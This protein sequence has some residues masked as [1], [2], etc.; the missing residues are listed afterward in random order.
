[1]G[2]AILAFVVIFLLAGSGLLLLFYRETLGQRLADVLSPRANS[3]DPASGKR[4]SLAE[5]IQFKK[6]AESL[7]AFAPSLRQA[8]EARGSAATGRQRLV[9]GGYRS[10]IA[11]NIFSVCKLIV[12]IVLCAASLV[13]G[14]Y[15]PILLL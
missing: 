8:D 14:L 4:L 12:P 13:T 6:Q 3:A 15:L 1:M 9:L 10:D 2:Y 11:V 7:A 5:R